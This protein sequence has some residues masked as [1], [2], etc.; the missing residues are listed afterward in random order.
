MLRRCHAVLRCL[1]PPDDDAHP[2]K[3]IDVLLFETGVKEV[4]V[5][6]LVHRLLDREEWIGQASAIECVRG[7]KDGLV[8]A[9]TWIES[10]IQSKADV[11]AWSRRTS[12]SAHFGSLMVLVSAK[13]AELS[14]DSWKLKA[15]IVFRGDNM[16]DEYGMSAVFDELYSSSPSSLEGLNTT[17]AFG[18]LDSHGVSVSDAI[19]A[20]VQSELKSSTH[21]YVIL[22]PE[23]VKDDKK[24]IKDPCARLYKAL[25]GHPLSSASWALHLDSILKGLGGQEFPNLSSVYFFPHLSLVLCVYVDDLT[26]SGPTIH[27]EGFWRSLSKQADLGPFTPLGRVL[28]RSHRFVLYKGVKALALETEDFARQCVDLYEALSG[29]AVKQ[30]QTPHVDPGSLVVSDEVPRGELPASAA[31][32]VMKLL[33]LARLSRPDI[34]VAVTLLAAKVTA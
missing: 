1:N 25:Y 30:F 6:G 29:K 8:N 22:P 2:L 14:P 31:R 10:Q 27:H 4:K 11:L 3:P 26:L 15:R 24:H 5:Q 18:L 23:L 9:G 21:T 28:G 34:L 32:M 17:I 12:N 13:G 20:Y 7:D 33:W 16:R 19:K